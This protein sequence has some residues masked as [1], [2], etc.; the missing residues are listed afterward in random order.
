[1][2]DVYIYC[3]SSRGDRTQLTF[4]N[5]CFYNLCETCVVS[6]YSFFTSMK[7]SVYKNFIAISHKGQPCPTSSGSV[8]SIVI[9]AH[10][11]EVVL[12]VV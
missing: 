7:V 12:W 10:Y 8:C 1:M 11:F 4:V 5:N 2:N 3:N 6:S 9:M